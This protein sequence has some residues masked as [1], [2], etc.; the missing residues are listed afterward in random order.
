MR[1]SL[2]WLL[3]HYPETGESL[4]SLQ[5]TALEQACVA[6]QLGFT[7]LWLAEHHFHTLGTVANPAVLLAAMAQRTSRL[8]LGPAVSVLPLRNP[9][10]VAEDYALVDLVSGGRLNMGVGSG[11]RPLEF[12]GFGIDFESRRELFDQNLMALRE[13]WRTARPGEHRPSSLH[14]PSLQSPAPPIYVSTMHEQGAHAIGLHGDSMLTLVSP[15]APDLAEVAAR[16]EEHARGLEDGGHADGA[17]EAVVMVL[18]HVAESEERAKEIAAPAIARFVGSILGAKLPDPEKLYDRML[19][20]DTALVGSAEHVAGQI[21]RYADLGIRHIAF[22]S[23]FGGIPA[24]AAA[25]SLRRL[26][27]AASQT[28][29]ERP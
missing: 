19:E 3:D 22:M 2:F 10:H 12:A 6:D 29:S 11:S 4:A 25:E 28:P 17:A 13:H 20:R 7:S 21:Q 18:A 24:E 15:A 27:P 5:A 16:V 8:R 14:V 26:A 9:I 1:R 23:Q